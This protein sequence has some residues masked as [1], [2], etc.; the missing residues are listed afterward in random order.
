[1]AL[2][3]SPLLQAQFYT[4]S[5]CDFA[6][7]PAPGTVVCL[8]DDAVSLAVPIGFSFE[9]YG[10]AFTDAYISS[11]GFLSFTAGLGS[12]CCSGQLLPSASFNNTIFFAQ[13]DLDPNSC[14]DG[15]IYYYTTGAPGSQVFV[16]SFVDVPHYPGP[17]GTFSV[18]SQVQLYEGTNEVKIVTTAYNSDGG[19]STMGLNHNGTE[20]DVVAGR[21]NANWSASNECISF[22]PGEPV[23][24]TG[25]ALYIY[26]NTTGG[27]PWFSTSNTTA[28]NAA[29]GTEGVGW[30]RAFF[31]TVDVAAAF[32]A[33]NC[34][35]FLEGSDA[36][37]NELETFL[38]ANIATIESWVSAGGR[39]LLNSAPNE[40]DGMSFGFGGTSLVY[41]YF[42]GTANAAD[43]GHP[44]F[45]G[46]ALPV[47][48]TWTGSSFG[49]ARITGTDL[50]NL[51]VDAAGPSN[52]VLA[53][54]AWGSGTVL[55]G[56]M[57]TN[58][59]HSP[60]T[61]AANLRSNILSYLA[62]AVTECPAPVGLMADGITGTTAHLSWDASDGSGGYHLS[63][64]DAAEVEILKKKLVGA[65]STDWTV[66]GLIP[67][68]EYA[69]HVRSICV[70]AG[71][72]SVLSD[73]YFFTTPARLSAED[74]NVSIY[75]N[76]TSGIFTIALNGYANNSFN[77]NVV[78][79]VGQ[80][81]YSSTITVNADNY[82]QTV[83]LSNVASGIYQ[84]NL[85][86]ETTIL[87]YSLSVGE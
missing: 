43:P 34:A 78:N 65:G 17:E 23:P 33:D 21:N 4:Q 85:S 63:V 55:F 77:V 39:L 16:M 84:V 29:F 28:M 52:I 2:A 72:K 44:I 61:E 83:D 53:E 64:Y 11:N 74:N 54:K 87:N 36:Q 80:V 49:H 75:P 22:L 20:A 7:M 48:T 40:G 71:I 68:A 58:N 50:T 27:E 76:P 57:T 18:T 79:T 45:N 14:V 38:T 32:S 86:N 46:P 25:N 30:N 59:F 56:G 1:M 51:I 66:T 81:V 6:P 47:G 31:E 73:N 3:F 10:T 41:S 69:F 9:F 8:G 12:A 67:G 13:E 5:T 60:A 70:G 42:T 62:C 24:V 82:T 26:S 19:L 37:A 15:D 35:I